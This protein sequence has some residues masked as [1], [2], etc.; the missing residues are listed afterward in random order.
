MQSPGAACSPFCWIC[1]RPV[2]LEKS[3]KDELGNIVHTECQT[4]RLKLR[5]AGSMVQK[6]AE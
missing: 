5:E 2:S 4:M 3:Q 1:N 6:K